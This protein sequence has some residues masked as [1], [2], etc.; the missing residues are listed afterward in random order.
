MLFHK[1]FNGLHVESVVHVGVPFK[2]RGEQVFVSESYL[3]RVLLILHI[4]M[5]KSREF[6]SFPTEMSHVEAVMKWAKEYESIH[7][8]G[9]LVSVPPHS[10]VLGLN[11]L[12]NN[13]LKLN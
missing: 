11:H 4:T 1:T 3:C 6:A 5:S 2:G 13:Q 10:R 7:D 8:D 12:F 9:P